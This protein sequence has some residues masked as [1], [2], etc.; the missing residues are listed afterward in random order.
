MFYSLREMV[1]S[2]EMNSGGGRGRL[3]VAR[4]KE[5]DKADPGSVAYLKD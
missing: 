1:L 2:G 5:R 3:L 4:R